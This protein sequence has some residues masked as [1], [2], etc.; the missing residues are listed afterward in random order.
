MRKPRKGPPGKTYTISCTDEQ[1][2]A[3]T[4]GAARAGMT[5]SRWFVHCALTVDPWPRKHRRVV[6]DERRVCP[7]VCVRRLAGI[8]AFRPQRAEAGKR[9]SNRMANCP[10]AAVQATGRFQRMPALRIAR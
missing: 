5:V 6:L 9:S 8:F 2:E 3:I 1:W 10:I 7:T 4:D